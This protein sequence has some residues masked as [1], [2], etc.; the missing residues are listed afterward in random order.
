MTE[1]YCKE[2]LTVLE[3]ILVLYQT[4]QNTFAIKN[5]NTDKYYDAYSLYAHTLAVRIESNITKMF[6]CR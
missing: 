4:K 5:R 2:Y 1:L 3:L 6:I